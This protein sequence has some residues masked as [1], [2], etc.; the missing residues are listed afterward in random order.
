MVSVWFDNDSGPRGNDL[1]ATDLCPHMN[2]W[3]K[4]QLPH[5]NT[6]LQLNRV[7]LRSLIE[8]VFSSFMPFGGFICG[9]LAG[10]PAS[11][12]YL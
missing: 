11:G 3:D 4:I 6:E 1:F 12:G 9:E 8:L 10:K 5:P 7:P 2:K